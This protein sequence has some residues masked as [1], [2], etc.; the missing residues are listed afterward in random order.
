MHRLRR[1]LDL[2]ASLRLRLLW[3]GS[4]CSL[5][6]FLGHPPAITNLDKF[7]PVPPCPQRKATAEML[8]ALN[9]ALMIVAEVCVCV[10][11]FTRLPSC[12]LAGSN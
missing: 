5:F 11:Q 12:V 1:T 3:I 4:P 6:L 9:R 10:H 8:N 7:S 2:T